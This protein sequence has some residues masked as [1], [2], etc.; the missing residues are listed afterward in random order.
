MSFQGVSIE[1]DD[2]DEI[3]AQLADSTA[4]FGTF[5][6][7][8]FEMDDTSAVFDADITAPEADLGGDLPF[9]PS[10]FTDEFFSASFILEMP[11]TVTTNNADEVLGDGR[12]RWDLPLLG[13]D[14]N[15][16]AESGIGG[17]GFPWLWLI[18][19]IILVAGLI[20]LI[21]AVTKR[22]N[23]QRQAVADAAAAHPST[24]PAAPSQPTETAAPVAPTQMAAEEP[25]GPD[26]GD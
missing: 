16:H 1:F 19:V 24:M 10:Q 9:D 2:V 15:F 20:A 21:V 7:F 14:K 6:S 5:T 8:T 22:S 11:G 12:L 13:G 3:T 26:T 18:I 4:E 17:S 23:Q 25:P